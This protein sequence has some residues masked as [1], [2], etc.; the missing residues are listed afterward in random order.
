[1]PAHWYVA[2]L[3]DSGAPVRRAAAPA[4][5]LLLVQELERAGLG[6]SR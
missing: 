1:M 4:D 6:V 3:L 5:L 2:E